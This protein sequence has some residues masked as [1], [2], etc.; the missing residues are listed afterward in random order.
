MI[1]V[2]RT[3]GRSGRDGRTATVG[4]RNT[5]LSWGISFNLSNFYVISLVIF[6][7]GRFKA[8]GRWDRFSVFTYSG[9]LNVDSIALLHVIAMRSL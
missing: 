5:L 8:S 1:I 9:M 3:D 2:G 4:Y 6:W 7:F